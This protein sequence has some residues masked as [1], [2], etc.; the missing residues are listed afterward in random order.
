[1]AVAIEV[2]AAKDD[3]MFLEFGPQVLVGKDGP[4]V[5]TP[6]AMDVIEL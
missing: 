4:R 5:L 1:L 2:K 3:Q 6:D